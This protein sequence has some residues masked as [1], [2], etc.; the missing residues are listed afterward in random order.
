MQAPDFSDPPTV[1]SPSEPPAA[2]ASTQETA[3]PTGHS[4]DVDWQS[5]EI[6]LAAALRD[7]LLALTTL[8]GVD[9]VMEQILDSVASVAPYDAATIMLFEQNQ[10]RVAYARGFAPEVVNRVKDHLIPLTKSHFAEMIQS[11]QAYLVE[12]TRRDP[13]WVEIPGTEWIRSSI[14]APIIVHGQ[15]IGLIAIDSGEPGHFT[16]SDVAR[17]QLFSRYAA[18]ALSNALQTEVLAQLVAQRTAELEQARATLELRESLLRSAQHIAHLGSWVVDPATRRAEWSEELYRIAG[19]EPTNE[20]PDPKLLSEMVLPEQRKQFAR[21]VREIEH[22]QWPIEIEL[23]FRRRSDGALRHILVRAEQVARAG[24]APYLVGTALDIT[25]R[26]QAEESLRLALQREQE[27]NQM[28]SRFVAMAAHEFRNPLSVILAHVEL[29]QQKWRSQPPEVVDRRLTLIQ[30]QA[31]G[32]NDI[33]GRLLELSRLQSGAID[34][35]PVRLDF[36]NLCLETIRQLRF[37]TAAASPIRFDPPPAPVWVEGDP[38]LLQRIVH[39]IVSN[40]QKYTPD[41]TPVEVRLTLAGVNARLSV[42]DHGI[43]I[44]PADLAQIF[45]PFHRG[46]NVRDIP[47]TGLGMAIVKHM[48]DLHHGNIRV[49]SKVGVGTTVTLELPAPSVAAAAT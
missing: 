33:V 12:D 7:S 20:P 10:A 32:L 22:G 13:N 16:A 23:A 19:M 47:G 34:F 43:G 11:G 1:W 40:A 15:V 18:L 21:L 29:L 39:N 24:G 41:A 42:Q 27:L 6:A 44:E 28:K 35:Q 4:N 38:V 31:V 26:K 3:S 9:A 8:P 5:R 36:A 49:E 14:G 17:V 37:T 2:E 48:V 25:E 30:A 46:V 45:E